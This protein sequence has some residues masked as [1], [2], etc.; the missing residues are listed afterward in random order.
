MTAQIERDRPPSIF[1]HDLGRGAPRMSR[2]AAAVKEEDGP[3]VGATADITHELQTLEPLE[4]ETLDIHG[5]S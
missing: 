3:R 4:S 2:L 1:R 5:N